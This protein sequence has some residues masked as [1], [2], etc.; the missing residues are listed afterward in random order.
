MGPATEATLTRGALRLDP[1]RH[2]CAFDGE[3]VTL[4][5]REMDLLAHLMTHPDHVATKAQ[6]TDALYGP[7]FHVSDRTLDSHL[8]NLRAKLAEAGCDGAIETVHGVGY[9]ASHT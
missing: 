6:L 8:R 5:A 1:G 2:I 9:K 4:T 7:T 3:T